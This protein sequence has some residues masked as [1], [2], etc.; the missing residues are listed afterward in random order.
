M[1]MAAAG[2]NSGPQFNLPPQQ[3]P[4]GTQQQQI[5]IQQQMHQQ[6]PMNQQMR[7][8]L[9]NEL[10]GLSPCKTSIL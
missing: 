7:V 4:Q 8:S 6:M 9:N 2:N 10:K 5:N 3:L 1:G